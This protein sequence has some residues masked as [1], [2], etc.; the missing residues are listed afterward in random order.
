MSYG[1]PKRR[2]RGSKSRQKIA[3]VQEQVHK[4]W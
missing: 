1:A 4:E 3:E 2:S